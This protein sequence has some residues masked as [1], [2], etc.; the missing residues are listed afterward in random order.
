MN[1]TTRISIEWCYQDVKYVADG[2]KVDITNEEVG[3][4]LELIRR[5]HDANL[6]ITWGTIQ[7]AIE[8]VLK[9]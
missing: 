8:E 2:M 7:Y 3:K 4:V 9:T 5:N 6:G 1:Y